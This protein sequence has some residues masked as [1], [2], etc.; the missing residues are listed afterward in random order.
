M[1]GFNNLPI[2]FYILALPLAWPMVLM[3]PLQDGMLTLGAL[4]VV[5]A[6]VA[7]A[8][9]LAGGSRVRLALYTFALV[10]LPPLVMFISTRGPGDIPMYIKDEQGRFIKV[11]SVSE[12]AVV[13]TK[14]DRGTFV[15]IS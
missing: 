11:D 12:D 2:S 9:L 5:A 3:N 6:E 4:L 14:D 10:F 8:V 13:Y 15:M 1:G 7:L